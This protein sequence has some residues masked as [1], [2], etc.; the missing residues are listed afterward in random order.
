MHRTR[1]RRGIGAGEVGGTIIAPPTEIRN[2]LR[3]RLEKRIKRHQAEL[4][5]DRANIEALNEAYKTSDKAPTL[6]KPETSERYI[7]PISLNDPIFQ[8]P[9]RIK[10]KPTGGKIK[11]KYQ[12]KR[13][14]PV[15]NKR[16]VFRGSPA[17][18][19]PSRK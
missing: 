1:A 3:A 12:T 17:Q 4:D 13:I 10:P 6:R 8:K 14:V 19:K 16:D 7:E 18:S 5:S 11:G 2:Q 15:V 9:I